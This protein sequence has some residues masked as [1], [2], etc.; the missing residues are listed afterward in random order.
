MIG[1]GNPGTEA[2][3][4][5]S[6]PPHS[7]RDARPSVYYARHSGDGGGSTGRPR[8]TLILLTSPVNVIPLA[9]IFATLHAITGRAVLQG[10]WKA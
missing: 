4:G 7:N 10:S 5:Q 2:G 1:G 8:A 9:P 6:R 3:R